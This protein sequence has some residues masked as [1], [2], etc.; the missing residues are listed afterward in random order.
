M[1]YTPQGTRVCDYEHCCLLGCDMTSK[2][3]LVGPGVYLHIE[4]GRQYVPLKCG[5]FLAEYTHLHLRRQ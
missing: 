5:K 4:D 2:N 3:I 1:L